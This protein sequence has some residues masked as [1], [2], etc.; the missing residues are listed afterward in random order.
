MNQHRYLSLPCS[1][2]PPSKKVSGV[3][4]A[5]LKYAEAALKRGLSV[6]RMVHFDAGL[7]DSGQNLDQLNEYLLAFFVQI[8]EQR[9]KRCSCYGRLVSSF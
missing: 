6:T 9:R 5:M 8:L 2:R 7:G 3:S 4:F 1:L